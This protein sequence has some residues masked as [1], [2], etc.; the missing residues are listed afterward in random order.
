M[1]EVFVGQIML[2]GGNFAPKGFSLCAGQILP[3]QQN[4]ALFSI[5]GTQYGGNGTTNFALPNLQGTFA[6]GAGDGNG[7]SSYVVGEQVGVPQ[8][9]LSSAEMPSHNHSFVASSDVG[10]SETANDG[11]L[12]TATGGGKGAAYYANFY[13][14]NANLATTPLS[15][16]EITVSGSSFAHNN[17]QPFLAITMCI[18]MQGTFPPRQ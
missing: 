7:L 8:V 13:S 6:I 2:F 12:A 11:I 9:T 10:V 5:L 1:S 18:A 16:M 3:I 17:M 15:P 4:T 14:A